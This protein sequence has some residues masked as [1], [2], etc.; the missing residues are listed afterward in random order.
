MDCMLQV[1]LYYVLLRAMNFLLKGFIFVSQYIS[2]E[3]IWNYLMNKC[4]Y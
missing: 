2:F 3:Q 1:L 4:V